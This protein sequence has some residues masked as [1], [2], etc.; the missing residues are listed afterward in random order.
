MLSSLLFATTVLFGS[1]FA[2]T[3]TKPFRDRIALKLTDGADLIVHNAKVFTAAECAPSNV[4]GFAVKDGVFVAVTRNDTELELFMSNQ[5]TVIDMD[6]ASV[7]PGLFDTHIHHIGG[8]KMLLR[9]VEFSSAL[10]LDEVLKA[11]DTYASN[12][13][14]GAWVTGGSWGSSLIPQLSTVEARYRLDNVSHGHPVFLADDTHHNAWANTAALEAAGI[15]LSGGDNLSPNIVLDP[16]TGEVTG[17]LIEEATG[18]VSAAQVAAEPDTLEDLKEYSLRAWAMLHSFGVTSIQDAAVSAPSLDAMVSLDKEGKLKGWISTCLTLSGSMAGSMDEAEF[19]THARDVNRDR[20]RTDFTKLV[21]DGV[22]PT[23]TGAFLTPYLPSENNETSPNYGLVYNTTAELVDTLRR[24]R[25]HGRHTKIHC[26]GDWSVQVA[27]DAFEALR[28]EGSQQTYHIAHGQFV[29]PQDRMRMQALD[30]VAEVSPFLWFPGIIPQSIAAVLPD[31]VAAHMQP[32]RD[33]LDLG[34]LVAGG[35]DWAVS[36]DPNPWEGIGG[37]VT[38]QDPTGRF[39]GTLWA[40]QAVSVE[41]GLRI[42][43]INGAKAARLDDVVGSIEVGKAANFVVPD[44]DPF[45]VSAEEL[46]STKVL[47]TYV[48]GELVYSSE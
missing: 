28:K 10:S 41:E 4:T 14:E 40:E 22:P 27:M 26:T 5:T 6:G 29:T 36:A 37:L 8:G 19:D 46:G 30:V 9:Q 2:T 43:T 42:F 24:Y 47:R 12:L 33:L 18:P 32:N 13:T 25:D 35:S 39:P 38:R 23:K 21:L 15:P 1:S 17:F 3:V 20:V 48:A 7:V 31:D 44:R 45:V 16:V 34:V 11:I